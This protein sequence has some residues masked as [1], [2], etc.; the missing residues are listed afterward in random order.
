[1]EDKRRATDRREEDG[2]TSREKEVGPRKIGLRPCL[3]GW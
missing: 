2:V 1:M 3:I